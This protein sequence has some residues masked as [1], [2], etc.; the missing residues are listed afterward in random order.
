[1][2]FDLSAALYVWRALPGAGEVTTHQLYPSRVFTPRRLLT[3][4]PDTAT[5]LRRLLIGNKEQLPR[6]GLPAYVFKVSYPPL[7]YLMRW[8]QLQGDAASF[9]CLRAIPAV[10]TEHLRGG[11]IEL[12]LPTVCRDQSISIELRGGVRAIGLLGSEP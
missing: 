2:T 4:D 5:I 3:W 1:M 9:F 7:D 11:T 8:S 6:G 10:L 12:D